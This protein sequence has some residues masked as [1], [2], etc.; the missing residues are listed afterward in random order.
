MSSASQPA[1]PDLAQNE[2]DIKIQP[3]LFETCQFVLD[4]DGFILEHDAQMAD[5]LN[6][7]P[8]QAKSHS[9]KQLLTELNPDWESQI[10]TLFGAMNHFF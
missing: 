3:F 5:K 10:L 4:R 9:F 2:N 8:T 6:I 7:P 1:S